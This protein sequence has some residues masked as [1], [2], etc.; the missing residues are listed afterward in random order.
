MFTHCCV[1]QFFVSGMMPRNGLPAFS[2]YGVRNTKSSGDQQKGR[3][4]ALAQQRSGS[5]LTCS[6]RVMGVTN[7]WTSSVSNSRCTNETSIHKHTRTHERTNAVVHEEKTSGKTQNKYQALKSRPSQAHTAGRE[8][9]RHWHEGR[10]RKRGG[11]KVP[12]SGS[13]RF[14]SCR[15]P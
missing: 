9:E 11:K 8:V 1:L 4:A 5:A 3:V 7:R 13:E 15:Q 12:Q 6:V 10:P 14:R 2:K